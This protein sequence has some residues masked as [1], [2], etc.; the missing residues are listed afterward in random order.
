MEVVD[1]KH[2]IQAILRKL[3]VVVVV[4]VLSAMAGLGVTRLAITPEYEASAKFYVNNSSIS[5]GSTSFS[6]SASE[7]TAAQGLVNTY[8]VILDSRLTLNEVIKVAKVN[9][10]YGQLLDMITSEQIDDTEIFKVTVT[11]TDPDEAAHLANTIA[12]VLPEKIAAIV[13]GSDVRV[14]DYAVV[15]KEASSPNLFVNVVLSFLLGAI[16]SLAAIVVYELMDDKIRTEDYLARAY[17]G[18]PL[19]AVIP[20]ARGQKSSGYYKSYYQDS[21]TRSGT[22]E[23]R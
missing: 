22:E 20:D 16:V 3:W 18:V 11:S 1:K 15:P 17:P 8:I 14:V 5:V 9:Y 2:L 19:L 13:D 23:S 12:V 21:H 6:I 4:A 10:T 7:L